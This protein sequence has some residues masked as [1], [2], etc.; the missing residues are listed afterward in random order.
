[1]SRS[2][3]PLLFQRIKEMKTRVAGR[4]PDDRSF[5]AEPR[6][7]GGSLRS[8]NVVEKRMKKWVQYG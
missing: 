1:M 4:L 7:S 6:Y 2:K 8:M 5:S 3:S